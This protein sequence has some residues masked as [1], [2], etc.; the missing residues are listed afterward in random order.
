MNERFKQLLQ[1]A[2]PGKAEF[3]SGTYYV[4]TPED[5]QKFAESIVKECVTA[6][7][8]SLYW[9]KTFENTPGP[10]H[11]DWLVSVRN[12]VMNSIRQHFGIEQ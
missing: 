9:E 10:T 12:H 11:P 5:M 6:A 1:E 4:A 8:Q 7:Y 3:D 2:I